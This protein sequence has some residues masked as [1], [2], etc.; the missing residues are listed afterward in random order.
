M[1]TTDNTTNVSSNGSSANE[2]K[3][4]DSMLAWLTRASDI[5][6]TDDPVG[7][8]E[9]HSANGQ[10]ESSTDGSPFEDDDHEDSPF[11][12]VPI[13]P[14]VE[15]PEPEPD[16]LSMPPKMRILPLI[17]FLQHMSSTNQRKELE[18][19]A[20]VLGLSERGQLVI[21]TI[22]RAGEQRPLSIRDLVYGL[23]SV[24]VGEAGQDGDILEETHRLRVRRDAAR[25]LDDEEAGSEIGERYSTRDLPEQLPPLEFLVRNLLV[26]HTHGPLGGP[27]KSLKTYTA[28]AG[29]VVPLAAGVD[30]FGRFEVPEARPV[31]VYI[32]EGGRQPY[33]RRL[34]RIC[35][36]YGLDHRR[37]PV[38]Y[39]TEIHPLGS[40]AFERMITTDLRDVEPGLVLLDPVYIF[41]AA[42]TQTSQLS[43][44]GA[45]MR[46]LVEPCKEAEA[47]CLFGDHFNQTG[48]GF[49]LHRLTGAGGAEFADSWFLQTHLDENG[50]QRERAR[51]ETVESGDFR[52]YFEVGSRQGFLRGWDLR[53]S[54]GKFDH[55]LGEHVGDV[56]WSIV[57]FVEP[58][59][60]EDPNSRENQHRT[61][62]EVLRTSN[63]EVSATKLAAELKMNQRLQ[64]WN[65]LVRSFVWVETLT[66]VSWRKLGRDTIIAAGFANDD[67]RKFVRSWRRTGEAMGWS[68]C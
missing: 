3:P 62:K 56:A 26:R 40:T 65:D 14:R 43:Q 54:V 8:A 48:S 51:R 42:A 60:D 16:W 5:P 64:K 55:D 23:D 34:I 63:G 19:L 21:L 50:K 18:R 36:A 45:E 52:L 30:A 31:V 61:V 24:G 13:P 27:W 47:V 25:A 7:V 33:E 68:E 57:P 67:T 53:F 15:E 1:S 37:L 32:G 58:D 59:E 39:R 66:E 2:P 12:D 6:V 44:V 49:G 46:R 20:P 38:E 10:G 29:L 22:L 28:T 11:G 17:D 9:E 35:R 41:R 4:V